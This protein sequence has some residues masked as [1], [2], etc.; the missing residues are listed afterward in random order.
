MDLRRSVFIAACLT[1]MAAGSAAA[2]APWPQQQQPA[3]AP[4]PDQPPAAG[5]PWPQQTL[6]QPPQQ[7]QEPPPCAK[8]FFKLRDDTETK[9]KA[10]QQASQRKATP[11]EACRLFNNFVAAE[12]KMIKYAVAN[13]KT[14][15]IPAEV[16]QT[17]N[18]GHARSSEIRARVCQAAA[19]PQQPAA[20][21]LSDALN[22]PVA[23]SNNIKTGRGTFDTLTGTPLGGK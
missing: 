19:R 11:V 10:I 2:Q 20:P 12:S 16:I 9:A 18:K 4:W 22:A 14:C 1:A 21:S 23:D 15:G 8:E 5:A 6:Q 17:M 13:A 3:A 7:Q